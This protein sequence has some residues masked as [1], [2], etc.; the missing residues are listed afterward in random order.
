MSE[1]HYAI[2]DAILP[3][4]ELPNPCPIRIDIHENSV[5]LYIG[6]RDWSWPRGCP[7]VS[8][9]GTFVGGTG[10]EESA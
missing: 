10:D 1:E 2:D 9:S 5:S 6:Q 7:D 4:L 8:G 3:S